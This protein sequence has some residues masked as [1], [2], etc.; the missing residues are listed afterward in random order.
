MYSSDYRALYD[1]DD[2]DDWK[3]LLAQV[4]YALDYFAIMALVARQDEIH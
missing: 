4:G 1:G 2:D 3:D